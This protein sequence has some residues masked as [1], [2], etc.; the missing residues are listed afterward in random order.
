MSRWWLA[1]LISGSLVCGCAAD[2][3]TS[4]AEA[5][6]TA[7][8]DDEL[9]AR[10]DAEWFYGGPMPALEQASVTV[11]LKGHTARL[12]GLLPVGATLPSLPHVRL[13]AEAGRTRVDAV[14]PIATARPGK[15]N[16]RA[17]TYKLQLVKPFRPDGA[18]FTPQEGSHFVPW[19]GFPFVAYNDGIAFH[20]PITSA[21]AATSTDDVWV[22]K[23]G[24]VS[25]G[26]NRMMG[27]HVVE[28]THALGVDMRRAY[29]A[30]EA[31]T[32]KR[33]AEVEVITDYDVWGGKLVDVDYP[34]DVGV[35]RPG[36]VVGAANVEMFG[37]WVASEQTGGRDLP[38]SLKW[39]AG[40]AG[41]PYVFAEHVLPDAVCSVP[42]ADLAKTRAYTAANGPLPVDFC[43][44][45]ACYLDAI[46]AGSTPRCR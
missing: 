28:L 34:T 45:R 18:A 26:C 4:D 43:A 36:K 25:G 32:P 33:R 2:V 6:S 46:R 12:S 40:V 30:N 19:G 21:D 17:G 37:S 14:Y 8:T 38:K 31:V 5:D 20:G 3:G 16:S 44:K 10:A 15:S 7:S 39:E 42:K 24:A 22:L 1:A 13:T 23:R 35:V 11:S 27:E 9:L 41:D 29:R